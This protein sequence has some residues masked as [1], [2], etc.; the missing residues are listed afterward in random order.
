MTETHQDDSDVNEPDASVSDAAEGT[1]AEGAAAEAAA[2]DE[3]GKERGRLE[4]LL[5]DYGAVA[6]VVWFGLFGLFIL[7][8][9]I[10]FSAG[11]ESEDASVGNG[12]F[13]ALLAAAYGAAWLTKLIRIP[14]VI[15]LTPIVATWWRRIRGKRDSSDAT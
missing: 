8:F 2:T 5:Y 1:V 7:G 14:I 10:A 11:F 12:G 13:L 3:G 4:Q 6:L 15:V 9:F